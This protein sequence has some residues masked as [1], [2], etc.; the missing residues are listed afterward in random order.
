MI[1]TPRRCHGYST[2]E[3]LLVLAI[4]GILGYAA[5]SSLGS[6]KGNAVR[7]VMDEVTGTILAAQRSA[8]NTGRSVTLAVNGKWAG[9]GA[10]SL[11]DG[12]AAFTM[13]PRPFDPTVVSPTA[14]DSAR[15]GATNERFV[16]MFAKNLRN[17]TTAGV[18]TDSTTSALAHTLESVAPFSTDATFLAALNTKLCT[19][20]QNA[21]VVDGATKR[22]T[23]GFAVVVVAFA[24]GMAMPN[25]PMG[26]IVVTPNSASVFRFYKSDQSTVWRRI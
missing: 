21:A 19:G 26:V 17:H 9:T 22:F 20:G 15:V 12:S 7:V 14:Y 23:T 24:S 25:G 4:V 3:L 18:A 11:T 10:A 2:I 5:V 6:P 13:D 16:S 1:P 8:T